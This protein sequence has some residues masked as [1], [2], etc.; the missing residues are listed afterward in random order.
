[1]EHEEPADLLG[2]VAAHAAELMA[3]DVLL[4]ALI[5]SHPKPGDLKAAIQLLSARLIDQVRDHGFD[6]GHKPS[7]AQS[8]I[9]DIQKYIDRWLA[10]L[11]DIPASKLGK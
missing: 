6:T 8:A 4:K 3:I 7:L 2:N 1:M 11:A 5:V 10:L 9:S